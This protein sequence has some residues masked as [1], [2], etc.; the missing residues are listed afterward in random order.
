MF[1]LFSSL[2]DP[3]LHPIIQSSVSSSSGAFPQ[4]FPVVPPPYSAVPN[5]SSSGRYSMHLPHSY[6]H[7]SY[8]QIPEQVPSQSAASSGGSNGVGYR[9]HLPPGMSNSALVANG[10]V[11]PPPP[12]GSILLHHQTSGGIHHSHHHHQHSAPST[13]VGS[14]V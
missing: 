4:H 10:R 8:A 14:K 2:A 7:S 11:P 13:N 3:N 5:S 12:P 9:G 6:Q 1:W